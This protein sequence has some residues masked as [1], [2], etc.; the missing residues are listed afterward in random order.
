ML[1]E[2]YHPK[3]AHVKG[4]G[5]DAADCLSRNDLED[6]AFDLVEGEPPMERLR[7]FFFDDEES[8]D[9]VKGCDNCMV[10][11][12]TMSMCDFEADENDEILPVTQ[13]RGTQ[14]KQN[15]RSV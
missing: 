3:V 9:S 12:E 15:S 4:V 7:Y 1:L 13:D 5:N 11:T 8:E 6:R 2:E 14:W 10:M